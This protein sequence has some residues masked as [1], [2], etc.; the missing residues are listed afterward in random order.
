M[1]PSISTRML[2]G[3]S[4]SGSVRG[5]LAW[6]PRFGWAVGLEDAEEKPQGPDEDPEG[7]QG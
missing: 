4:T 1:E 5:S 3:S 7:Q 2:R 6:V